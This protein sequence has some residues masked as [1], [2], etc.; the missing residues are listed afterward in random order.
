MTNLFL[1]FS[2]RFPQN[3][4]SPVFTITVLFLF[5]DYFMTSSYLLNIMLNGRWM[6][7]DELEEMWNEAVVS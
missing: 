2:S 6:M 3:V 4:S 5:S 1:K 7:Y